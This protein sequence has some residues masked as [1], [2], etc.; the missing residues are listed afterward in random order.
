MTKEK[1]KQAFEE[2]IRMQING[3]KIVHNPYQSVWHGGLTMAW[4]AGWYSAKM[5]SMIDKDI[6]N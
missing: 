1:A 5:E 4:M 6:I 3:F 2:G